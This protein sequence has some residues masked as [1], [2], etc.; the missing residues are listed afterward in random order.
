MEQVLIYYIVVCVITFVLVMLAGKVADGQV[1]VRDAALSLIASLIPIVN[2]MFILYA[3]GTLTFA[4][5][6]KFGNRK[7]L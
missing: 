3:T 2:L 5:F 7:V 4:F 1:T 6:A